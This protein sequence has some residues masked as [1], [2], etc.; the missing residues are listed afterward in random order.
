MKIR[1]YKVDPDE[2]RQM[3]RLYLN[4]I[5][6]W[7]KIT[8]Q[9]A[10]KREV[11]RSYRSRRRAPARP[12]RTREPFYGVADPL[13]RSVYVNDPNNIGGVAALLDALIA[14]DTR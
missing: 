1:Q 7:K 3:R 9:L 5:F 4:V 2:K 12:R 10:Q 13:T 6:D 8:G 14:H 11:C